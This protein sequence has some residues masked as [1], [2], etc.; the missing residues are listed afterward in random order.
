MR[1]FI[2]FCFI[3]HPFLD[4]QKHCTSVHNETIIVIW[5]ESAFSPLPRPGFDFSFSLLFTRLSAIFSMK[6]C[7]LAWD[8]TANDSIREVRCHRWNSV[9]CTL[10]SLEMKFIER[11]YRESIQLDREAKFVVNRL[12]GRATW[13][14]FMVVKQSIKSSKL[15][16]MFYDQLAVIK[17]DL[18][19]CCDIWLPSWASEPCQPAS[20]SSKDQ[21][22]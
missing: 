8:T 20:S 6:C 1:S 12:D 7:R 2:K 21:R 18:G 3:L 16:L 17:V 14:P 15:R 5:T 10:A 11:F 13:K 19:S 9:A 22:N 4:S